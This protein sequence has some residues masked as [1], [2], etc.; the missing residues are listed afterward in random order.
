MNKNLPPFQVFVDS[1]YL[2]ENYYDKEDEYGHLI[3]VRSLQNQA[4]QFSVLLESGALYT[5]LPLNALKFVEGTNIRP[6]EDVLMWDNI[7]SD[8]DVITLDTLLYMPCSVK[9]LNGEII[10]GEYLFSIDYV[11]KYDLSRSPEHW[12]QTHFIKGSDGLCYLYPQYSIKF[13]DRALCLEGTKS[14]G[15]PNYRHNLKTYS[16]GG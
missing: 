8:I 5:G 10:S 13:L 7:S 6:L 16:V 12:K 3:S 11:G 2:Y 4:L 15:L 14:E 1:C 9:L